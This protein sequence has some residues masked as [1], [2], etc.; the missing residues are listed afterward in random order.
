MINLAFMAKEAQ[1]NGNLN[2]DISIN[3]MKDFLISGLCQRVERVYKPNLNFAFIFSSS[4][5]L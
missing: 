4:V 5:N 3:L 1:E 2:K